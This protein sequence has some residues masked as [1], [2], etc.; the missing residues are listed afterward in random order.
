MTQRRRVRALHLAS[1]CTLH[2]YS[3]GCTA[4][5]RNN[6][7]TIH[8]TSAVNKTSG[9]F[10]HPR[11]FISRRSYT[12]SRSSSFFSPPL[13]SPSLF[14]FY[15]L[16]PL[17]SYIR[18]RFSASLR[19]PFLL[20]TRTPTTYSPRPPIYLIFSFSP[21]LPVVLSPS[22]RPFLRVSFSLLS[23]NQPTNQPPT[24]P[25]IFSISL[26]APF[27]VHPFSPL[28]CPPFPPPLSLFRTCVPCLR[29]RREKASASRAPS[30]NFLFLRG[31]PQ[32]L[33]IPPVLRIETRM[34]EPCTHS[35]TCLSARPLPWESVFVECQAQARSSRKWALNWNTFASGCTKR[36]TRC[37][38]CYTV[39][40]CVPCACARGNAIYISQ[41]P[42]LG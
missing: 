23:P 28:C 39:C 12:F 37:R 27:H 30:T 24:H 25:Y 41:P 17:P 19:D 9:S 18:A 21:V 42:V 15:Y 36:I 35:D 16:L 13:P 1:C 8:H 22:R 26:S 10:C 3:I 11:L 7:V 6:I 33:M 40:L 38:W 34:H 20:P 32:V 14:P 2:T 31:S 5:Q 4:S 29:R